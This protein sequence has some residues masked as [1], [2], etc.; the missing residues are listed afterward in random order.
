MPQGK[1]PFIFIQI[2]L[3][4]THWVCGCLHIYSLDFRVCN[5]MPCVRGISAFPAPARVFFYDLL[6]CVCVCVCASEHL[7]KDHTH[8]RSIYGLKGCGVDFPAWGV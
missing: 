1:S 2:R 6:L 8:T 4:R 7:L 3:I 5:P